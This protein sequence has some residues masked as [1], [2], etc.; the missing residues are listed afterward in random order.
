MSDGEWSQL[1]LEHFEPQPATP[2]S[3]LQTLY[4]T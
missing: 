3:N 2:H 4:V 1:A